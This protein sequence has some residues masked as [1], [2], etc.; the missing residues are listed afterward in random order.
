MTQHETTAG[1]RT[2]DMPVIGA[3]APVR[4]VRTALL[5]LLGTAAVVVG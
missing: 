3:P 4:L 2:P 5:G 1:S